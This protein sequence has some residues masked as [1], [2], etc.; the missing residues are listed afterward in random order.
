YAAPPILQWE[1]RVLK[2]RTPHAFIHKAISPS[3]TSPISQV[4]FLLHGAFRISSLHSLISVARAQVTFLKMPTLII[5][6]VSLDLLCVRDTPSR[7]IC[8]SRAS[9]N[10]F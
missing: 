10:K 5:W 2:I 6:H 8:V 9:L 4:E 3:W 1:L 7:L